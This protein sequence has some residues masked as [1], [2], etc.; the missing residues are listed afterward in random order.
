MTV[1]EIRPGARRQ[2]ERSAESA[3]RLIDAAIELGA[4]K[5]FDRMTVRELCRHG[6][7][8][9]AMVHERYGSKAGLLRAMMESEF[10]TWVSPVISDGMSGLEIALEHVAATERAAR[11]D[12][13]RLRAFFVL[14]YETT[15]PISELAGWMQG[16]NARYR[17]SVARALRRGQA[18]GSVRHD[19]DRERA[20]HQVITYILGAGL[21]WSL[22]PEVMD[23]QEELPRWRSELEA[24]WRTH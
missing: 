7:Y 11:Q 17:A 3:R 5:G 24:A 18:D 22:E 19:L 6:G 8:S 12:P 10:E 23:L 14:C 4:E 2:T 9:N 20:A 13:R 21:Q 16:A 15:G 1:S